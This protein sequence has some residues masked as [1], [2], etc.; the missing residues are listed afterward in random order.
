[1]QFSTNRINFKLL[2]FI[3]LKSKLKH[4]KAASF[5]YETYICR[6]I[7]S[8][9]AFRS[10]DTIF[11][12]VKCY[13]HLLKNLIIP[14]SFFKYQNDKKTS[15]A[16]MRKLFP[17]YKESLNE[18]LLNSYLTIDYNDR[19]YRNHSYYKIIMLIANHHVDRRNPALLLNKNYFFS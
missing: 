16:K 18:I 4:N 17:F 15:A 9:Y 6:Y 1:M 10:W 13:S 14:Y 2:N 19:E 5:I 12:K 3:F 8:S 11:N 7:T